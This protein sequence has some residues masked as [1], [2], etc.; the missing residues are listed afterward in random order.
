MKNTGKLHDAISSI[1]ENAIEQTKNDTL[2][3]LKFVIILQFLEL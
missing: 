3:S 1:R 2:E